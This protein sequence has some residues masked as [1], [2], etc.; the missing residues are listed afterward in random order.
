MIDEEA[1]SRA[2]RRGEGYDMLASENTSGVGVDNVS[3]LRALTPP[4][5]GVEGLLNIKMRWRG[6]C[7]DSS[8]QATYFVS[9]C[10]RTFWQGQ[11]V[12]IVKWKSLRPSA[13]N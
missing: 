9:S 7:G 4:S 2:K 11:C 8:A 12:L 6:P 5:G 1:S 3:A 13:Q 10:M